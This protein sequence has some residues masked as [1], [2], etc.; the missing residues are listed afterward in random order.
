LHHSR[1]VDFF[2]EFLYGIKEVHKKENIEKIPKHTH[3]Y[4]LRRQGPC[5]PLGSDIPTL[6][7]LYGKTGIKDVT[8]KLYK[9]ARHELVNELNRDEVI[10]DIIMWMNKRNPSA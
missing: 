3:F 7:R 10:N 2:L 4:H 1:S 5:G 8:Y 9:D 6:A